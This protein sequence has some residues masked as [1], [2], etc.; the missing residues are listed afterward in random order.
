MPY[1]WACLICGCALTVLHCS[2]MFRINLLVFHRIFWLGLEELHR[3]TSGGKWR[4][5][6]RVKWDKNGD[7]YRIT[8]ADSRA[9]THGESE[10]D[11]FK[12]GSEAT[13]Y[14]LG[15]GNQ[16]SKNNWK[17]D[18]FQGIGYHGHYLDG[19]QFSTRDHDHDRRG[20]GN[21]AAFPNR[22]GWWFN[23]CYRICLTCNRPNHAINDGYKLRLPS[24]AEMWIK[25]V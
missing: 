7:G 15:I 11:D 20:G 18:P 9:G 13:N 8:E 23:A 19:M 17:E 14:Q 2:S 4:L 3:L 24:L 10:W 22:G 21:C 16:L 1:K 25:K 12:I 5:K 6:V